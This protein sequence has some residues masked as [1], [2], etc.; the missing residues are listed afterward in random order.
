MQRGRQS[1]H[2]S[3][4]VSF[5][6]TLGPSV[7]D[8]NLCKYMNGTDSLTAT[9]G[10]L[11]SLENEIARERTGKDFSPSNKTNYLV[12]QGLDYTCTSLPFILSL[13]RPIHSKEVQKLSYRA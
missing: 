6:W 1:G 2:N 3:L 7:T 9:F 8:V 13:M 5:L 4:L 12:Q 10:W 11:T